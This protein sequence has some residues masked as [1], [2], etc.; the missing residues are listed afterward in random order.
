MLPIEYWPGIVTVPVAI[1][2]LGHAV[3]AALSYLAYRRKGA[4]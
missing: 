4:A 1:V 3:L 2:V